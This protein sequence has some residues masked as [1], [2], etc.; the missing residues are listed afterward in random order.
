[1]LRLT[2]KFQDVWYFQGQLPRPAHPQRGLHAVEQYL[3]R[4]ER[5][6]GRRGAVLFY[7]SSTT[8]LC[9]W[10]I[11]PTAGS[12]YAH[13]APLEPA[14]ALQ[15]QPR[16]RAALDVSGTGAGSQVDT[17]DPE[18]AVL[19]ASEL[20]LPKAIADAIVSERIDT[21]IVVPSSLTL[22]GHSRE[23]QQRPVIEL[24]AA[25][26]TVPFPLLR[27]G[28]R[29]ERRLIDVASVLIAPGFAGFS[30][31][32][33][34]TPRAFKDP[35][36]IG[37]PSNPSFPA[38]VEARKE[39]I[40]IAASLGSQALVDGD[41]TKARVQ[42]RL[43]QFGN[44]TQLIHMATH[45]V[46]DAQNPL[47]GSFLV[48]SDGRLTAREISKLKLAQGPLVVMSA[49]DTGLGRDFEVGTI[50]LARA[51]QHAGAPTVVMS[52]WKVDDAA[53]RR[54][55]GDFI[56]LA[57]TEPPDKAL[58]RAMQLAL[59]VNAD[60][61]LWAGFAIFGLPEPG[62]AESNSSRSSATCDRPRGVL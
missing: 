52:L 16:L 50:G 39:A 33:L 53:T 23:D 43:R 10:L 7:A 42:E 12:P 2:S 19:E 11:V 1:M 24:M 40:D 54:L 34:Q 29:R 3:S 61:V 57:Q 36:V 60:P 37:N 30:A 35:L 28:A 59:A 48:M 14:S 6:Q 5:E 20:L 56:R 15:I 58:R 21:L 46:A 25:V 51:W 55:M 49:C 32:R 44:T 9:S 45:G 31:D 26:G 4:L 47:D 18:A 27:V 38:L 22:K 17:I 8:R 13:V 41:A 62:P